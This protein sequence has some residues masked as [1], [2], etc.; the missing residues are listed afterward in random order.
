M[1]NMNHVIHIFNH[2]PDGTIHEKFIY[3]PGFSPDDVHFKLEYK[4]AKL[5]GIFKK[6]RKACF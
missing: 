2:W 4:N 5:K 1:V 3:L 6:T